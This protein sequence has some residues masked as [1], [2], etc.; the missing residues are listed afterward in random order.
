[1][2]LFDTHAHVNDSEAFPAVAEVWERAQAV[3]VKRLVAPGYDRASCL[4]ALELTERFEGIYAAVG[5][6][7]NDALAV[8][9]RDLANLEEWSKRDKV[10]AIGE[11]GLDY[12]YDTPRDVQERL[13]REQIALA[14]RV[15][16][17][18][19]IHDREAH[20]DVLRLLDDTGAS[21][22]GGIMH[23]FS[24][25]VEMMHQCIALNMHI[26][27][28]GPVTFKNAKKPLQV[29]AEVPFERLLIETDSPWLAP[30]PHRGKP[31]EPAYVRLVAE[32]I[33]DVRGVALADL[34]EQTYINALRLFGLTEAS[35]D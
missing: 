17:P 9:D 4:R 33:A 13:L 26:S 16:K 12:H 27:L 30:H 35:Y 19:V 1:M 34:A 24:G 8:T 15:G 18:I 7:P 2:R 14:R 10:V 28:G 23:C 11:I 22:V 5:F 20:E 21:Q 31:N 32:R 6:H 3:G 29:A 25:S